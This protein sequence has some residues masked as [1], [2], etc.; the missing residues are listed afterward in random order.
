MDNPGSGLK[1]KIN[2]PN[3]FA[4]YKQAGSG[5]HAFIYLQKQQATGSSWYMH[6]QIVLP[7]MGSDQNSRSYGVYHSASEL[8][9][10]SQKGVGPGCMLV[11]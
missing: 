2:P 7:V 9:S 5:M 1:R 3:V 4:Q 11:C 8:G 10:L 6:F